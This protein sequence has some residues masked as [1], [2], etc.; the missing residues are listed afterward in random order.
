MRLVV[1]T[2]RVALVLGSLMAGSTAHAQFNTQGWGF[3]PANNAGGTITPQTGC[4]LVNTGI[5]LLAN[6]GVKILVQ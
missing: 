3:A 1:K 6:T 5:C 4:I 2:L